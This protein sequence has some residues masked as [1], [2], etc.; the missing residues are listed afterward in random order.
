VIRYPA[1]H[2]LYEQHK[3]LS[4]RSSLRAF[5]L[6]MSI[7]CALSTNSWSQDYPSRA[8]RLIVPFAP[9]GGTDIIARLIA[10]QLSASFSQP[11]IVDNRPGGGTTI[12]TGIA[13]AAAPDGYTLVMVASTFTAD[14]ALYQTL[15]YNPVKSFTPITRVS[16]F[17]FVLVSHP[18]LPAKSVMEL[19]RYAK[20]NPGK[21]NYASGSGSAP[22]RLG[23]ELFKWQA[24]VNI[25][26]IP[27]KGAGPAVTALLSGETQ[28]LF[29]TLPGVLPHIKTGRLRPLAIT[30]ASRHSAVPNLPT[31]SESGLPGY[32]FVSWHG[33]L[34]PTHTPK[35]V[36]AR[37][38]SE[39]NSIMKQPEVR[40]RLAKLGLDA[41]GTSPDEFRILISNEVKKW[42]KVVKDTGIQAD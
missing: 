11:V 15:P 14:A 25:V 23:M 24:G 3:P 12:G 41:V 18:S 27:Y 16:S 6:A 26:G 31:I 39:I 1:F 28:L 5:F 2:A 8:V 30:S 34:A 35:D 20:A 33:V 38:N 29:S 36:I 13:A 10:Q 37:L 21:L 40:E 17:P 4:A 22:A 7:L 42:A 32:E 19:I 9:S